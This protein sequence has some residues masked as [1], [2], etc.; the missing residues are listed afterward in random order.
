[1]QG[2][3][4]SHLIGRIYDAALRP[5]LWPGVLGE[6]SKFVHGHAAAI[7]WKDAAKKNGGVYYED[8]GIDP[9]FR[10]LYFDKYVKLDPTTTYY[11]FAAIEAPVASSDLIPFDEFC[12]TRFYKEWVQPQGLVDCANI[13]VEKSTTSAALFGVFRHARHGL[14]DDEMRRRMQSIAPHVRRAMLIGRTIDLRTAEAATFADTFE[15]LAAGMVLVDAIGR[16]VHANAAGHAMLAGD[17]LRVRDGRLMANDAE[18]D[19]Q[20]RDV[21]AVAVRGDAA[22]GTKGIAV[23]LTAR[24]G[25]RHV[26]HVL[27]LTSGGRRRAGRACAAVAALFVHKAALE[28]RT[29]PEVMAKTFCLTATELRVLLAIVEVGGTPEAA[30]VLG[31]AESTVKTHLV[32]LYAK[33]GIRRQADLVRLVAEFS[34][35]LAG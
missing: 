9:H 25:G 15:G 8:G 22:V 17:V 4:L 2:E 23:P 12:E 3:Q 21:F 13:V 34:S 24:D 14:V 18:A 28:I 20:L 1:M 10:Q 16:V 32:R 31:I 11:F 7:Y 35:P 29:P 27:P 33:T 5:A 26:A 30:E 19:R 6:A